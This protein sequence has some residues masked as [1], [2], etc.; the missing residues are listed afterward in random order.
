M[1]TDQRIPWQAKF[2][3]LALIWGSS[4]LFMKVSLAALHPIQ[5]ATARI[6][7]AALILVLLLRMTGGRLPRERRVWGHL[8]VSSVFLTALPFTGFVVGETRVASAIAGIGNATTPIAAVLFAIV[9]L[10]A[11]R[12]TGANLAAVLIGFLGVIIIAEPWNTAGRPDPL[13]FLIVVLSGACYGLGWTYNRRYLAHADLGGLS[14]PAALLL[15]GSAL[16]V[17]VILIWWLSSDVA[18]PWSLVPHEGHTQYPIWLGLVC[19]ALL[20]FVGTG[21]AYMLQFDVVRAAGAVAST[22]VTYLIPV[23]SVVLGVFVLGEHLGA[24]QLLGFAVVLACAYVIN[25]KPRKPKAAMA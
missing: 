15:C 10:P 14:Q 1:S 9:L 11:E 4:F 22:T 5:I 20:G 12:L 3:A 24:A 7:A 2:L 19:V 16:M 21:I 18:T 8:A 23:V 6:L 17:P 25:A 13:G